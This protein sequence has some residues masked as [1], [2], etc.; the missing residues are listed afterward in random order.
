MTGISSIIKKAISFDDVR[1]VEDFS[2]HYKELYKIAIFKPSLDL[3]LTKAEQGMVKFTLQPHDN[4]NRL[5]GCCITEEYRLFNKIRNSFVRNFKHTINIKTLSA[6]VMMHEMAHAVEKESRVQ[7][8]REFSKIF[9]ADLINAENSHIHIQT[10]VRQVIL[11]EIELY[12][13]QQHD[14]E[15]FARFY[16]LLAMSKE[17]SSYHDDFHFKLPEMMNVFRNTITWIDQV[18]NHKLK[19][20]IATHIEKLT[21]NIKF[22][23][24]LN[25]FARKNKSIHGK[26]VKWKRTV[27]SLFGDKYKNE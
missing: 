4:L 26:D 19:H 18:F 11:K 24:E 15:Y 23:D 20:Q 12:P 14:S 25:N 22:D 6:E 9:R 1:K 27:G 17:I 5:H 7:L 2:G 16:Q 13:K 3:M 21:A 10:A 8:D